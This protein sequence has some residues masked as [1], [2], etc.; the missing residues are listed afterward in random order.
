VS[1]SG[2]A[3]TPT[4]SAN[5]WR[6]APSA[7]TPPRLEAHEAGLTRLETNSTDI[8][9]TM[10][11]LYTLLIVGGVVVFVVVGLTQQ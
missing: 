5:W 4:A 3:A 8:V 7:L 11:V 10:F 2:C 9:R 1:R 6:S